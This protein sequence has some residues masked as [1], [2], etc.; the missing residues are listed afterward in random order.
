MTVVNSDSWLAQCKTHFSSLS[1]TH[2]HALFLPLRS[3]KWLEKQQIQARS[4]ST[5]APHFP[6]DICDHRSELYS[7]SDE[8]N[9][10]YSAGAHLAAAL[11]T[12]KLI[13]AW[14]ILCIWKEAFFSAWSAVCAQEHSIS[15][16][17]QS[18]PPS[19]PPSL[20][21]L[22]CLSK[23]YSNEMFSSFW[24]PKGKPNFTC[25]EHLSPSDGFSG[26]AELFIN[27]LRRS[28][29]VSHTFTVSVKL[30]RTLC[31][32]DKYVQVCVCV[33]NDGSLIC[34]NRYILLSIISSLM[35]VGD[36]RHSCA[37]LHSAW[38]V[39]PGRKPMHRA[40]TFTFHDVI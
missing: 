33:F 32:M 37:V 35:P 15:F 2:T 24:T 13:H 14:V 19:L 16:F 18:F 31:C 23:C 9:V 4:H 30:W 20:F 36:I 10:P 5:A 39:L 29:Q 27:S 6:C 40:L 21:L 3:M 38:L 34:F 8:R 12:L 22:D 26:Q 7:S 1:N 25:W 28:A 11:V 17:H